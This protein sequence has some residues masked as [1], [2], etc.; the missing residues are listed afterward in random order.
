VTLLE[1][2]DRAVPSLTR[3]DVAVSRRSDITVV[4]PVLN[5]MRFL[6]QT[7]PTLLAAGRRA[8]QVEFIYVDNG[9]TDGS[10]DYLREL[11]SDGIRVYSRKGDTIAGMRNFG[12]RQ[13]TGQYLS[14]IDG[15]CS[16]PERYFEI[17]VSVLRSTGAAATGCEICVPEEPHWIESAW[18]D[19]HYVGRNR[20][21]RYLN[22]GNFFVSRSAFERVGGFREDM[23]TGEDA[24]LGERLVMAGERI[25]ACP[26]VRAIHLG[27]PKSI[28]QFYRRNVWHGL[29]MFG[30]V[31]WNR[32][33]RPTVMLAVHLIATVVGF[34]AL[35]TTTLSPVW[36]VSTALGLQLV[37]PLA[38]VV[39]RGQRTGRWRS[40]A[41]GI[42]LYWLYYWA[43]LHALALVALGRSERYRK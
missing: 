5:G 31:S 3:P 21:V 42:L 29:G 23:W 37:A 38:T 39:Y 16:I 28:P 41:S 7:I 32:L 12:A 8:G 36:R 22:S 26:D 2:Q 25:R 4:V 34:A 14:F 30:T 6:P 1:V 15:D 18:H 17:A 20:D 43:R 19:L 10:D 33:D 13:G 24:E 40:G 27:N 11:G 35:L 9:S